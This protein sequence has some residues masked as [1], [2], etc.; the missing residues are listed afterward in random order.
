MLVTKA[1]VKAL[2]VDIL[3][4]VPK[5]EVKHSFAVLGDPML[6]CSCN[7]LGANI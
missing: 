2:D 1:G 5:L 4:W 3:P 6:Y 7:E